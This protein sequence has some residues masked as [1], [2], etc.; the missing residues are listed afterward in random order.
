MVRFIETGNR[1]VVSGSWRE[2]G[3]GSYILKR[4][5]FSV[6]EDEVLEMNDGD[7]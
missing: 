2:R 1:M 7:G 6:W 4:M 3:M 5:E